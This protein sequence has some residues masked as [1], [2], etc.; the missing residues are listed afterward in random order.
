MISLI[1]SPFVLDILYWTSEMGIAGRRATVV[2]A[3][4]REAAESDLLQNSTPSFIKH[5]V[6][7]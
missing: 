3:D 1:V 5:F 7:L 4:D 6:I 2:H